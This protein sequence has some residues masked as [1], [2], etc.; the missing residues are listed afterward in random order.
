VECSFSF[1]CSYIENQK[2]YRLDL[3]DGE[4]GFIFPHK[5]SLRTFSA[6]TDT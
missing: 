1:L 2:D 3:L 4:L 5:L 6:S